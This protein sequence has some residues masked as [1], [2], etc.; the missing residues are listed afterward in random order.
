MCNIKLIKNLIVSLTIS[1]EHIFAN[2]SQ[3]SRNYTNQYIA[4]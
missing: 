2:V 1:A 3:V 4:N